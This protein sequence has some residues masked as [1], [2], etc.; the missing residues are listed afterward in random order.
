MPHFIRNEPQLDQEF[1]GYT[2]TKEDK[3]E[4]RKT[5]NLGKVVELAD[6][7]TGEMKNAS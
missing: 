3:A 1:K 4:L 5:G 2:F 7:K 6:P